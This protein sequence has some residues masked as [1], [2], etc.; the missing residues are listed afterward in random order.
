VGE[1]AAGVAHEIN[2][3][4]TGIVGYAQL[5][6]SRQDLPEDVKKDLKIVNDGAQ[7]VAGIVQRLLTFARQV[8]PERRQVNINQLIESTLALRTYSLRTSN[9]EV[10]T[11]LDPY[12]PDTIADP[13]QIQQ[14]LLNLIVNAETAMKEVHRKR[15]LTITTRKADSI[16]EIKVKDNGHGIKPEIMDRIFDPFFTTRPAGEGTGL[17]LSLCYGIVTEHNGR[18]YAESKPGRGATFV[19]ELPI[20]SE[21]A[22]PVQMPIEFRQ[23]LTGSRILVVDDEPVIRDFINQVLS[24]EGCEVDTAASAEEALQKIA[25]Q[26][27]NLLLLDIKMPGMDGIELYNRV[28]RL[29]RSLARRVVF[30][31]GDVISH[32]TERFLTE[33]KLP[34][35]EKPFTATQLIDKL[36]RTLRA[37]R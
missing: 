35:I 17:G 3:P 37:G 29:G 32:G 12:L 2:N 21:V 26:Q 8:K 11:R 22:Q 5:L 24:W 33:N 1:M 19:V 13:G 30:I 9:I 15:R 20:V 7:R 23:K 16:V 4:L 6:A 14:V 31:T 25:S 27:Y 18:I 28:K 36:G 34:H 10:T